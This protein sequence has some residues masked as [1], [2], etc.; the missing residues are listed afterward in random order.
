MRFWILLFLPFLLINELQ[1]QTGE[2]PVDINVLSNVVRVKTFSESKKE[3]ISGTGFIVSREVQVNESTIRVKFL[4]T[5]KHMVSDWTF[6]DGNTKKF[7]KYLDVDF[8]RSEFTPYHPTSVK[9]I[10]LCDKD[11]RVIQNKVSCC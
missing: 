8:Y 9:R 11:G 2:V 5:N 6:A 7:N 1:A 4:V 10:D 3:P